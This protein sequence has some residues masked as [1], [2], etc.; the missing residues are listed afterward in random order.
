MRALPFE[1]F[2][3]VAFVQAATLSVDSS[4]VTSYQAYV[5]ILYVGNVLVQS[6][7]NQSLIV[8]HL[9]V[10]FKVF[11]QQN[12]WISLSVRYQWVFIE[13]LSHYHIS[14]S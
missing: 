12:A 2:D 11:C 5:H 13:K 7:T 9:H 3:D 4:S 8:M 10:D 1:S 6:K 14:S